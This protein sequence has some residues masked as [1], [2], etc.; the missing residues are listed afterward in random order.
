MSLKIDLGT[1]YPSPQDIPETNNNLLPVLQIN[2]HMPS[3]KKSENNLETTV[4]NHRLATKET[5]KYVA[6]VKVFQ[7]DFTILPTATLPKF[8][9]LQ[10]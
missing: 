1:R 2:S 5:E 7:R 6:L 3:K 8:H 9:Y 4:K 10:S